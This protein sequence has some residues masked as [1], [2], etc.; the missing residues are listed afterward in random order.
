MRNMA[1]AMSISL[2]PV[3]LLLLLMFTS[4][5]RAEI[6][7]PAGDFEARYELSNG[8]GAEELAKNWRPAYTVTAEPD[9]SYFEMS[10]DQAGNA[11]G[12]V[13]Y[14]APFDLP[15][16][17]PVT[18]RFNFDMQSFDAQA[19]RAAGISVVILTEDG[20]NSLGETPDADVPNGVIKGGDRLFSQGVYPITADDLL[21]WTPAASTNLAR[22]IRTAPTRRVYIAIMVTTVH[23]GAEEWAKIRDFRIETSNEP[24]P[25]IVR[26][27]RWPLK[28]QRTL[29]T[30]EEITLARQNCDTFQSAADIRTNIINAAQRWMDLPDDEVRRRIP[31]ADV[32]RAANVNAEGCPIHG[33]EVYEKA[34]TYPWQ[35]DWDHPFTIKCPVG[36]EVY[37]ANDFYATYTDPEKS[38]G[39]ELKQDYADDGWGWVAPDGKRYWLVGY[40]CHWWWRNFVLPGVLNLSRAYVLTGDPAY[41]HKAAIML[42]RIAEEYPAMD[43]ESQSRYGS[44]TPGDYNG[45]ILNLIWETFTLTDLAEAYDNI[46]PAIDADSDLHTFLGKSG[47]QIRDNIETNLLQ[48]GIDCVFSQFI[49]GNF[50]MHQSALATASVVRQNCP[51][52]EHIQWLLYNTGAAAAHEGMQYALYN[53]VF[54]DG[55]P[56]ETS[57]GYCY[58]WV[59]KFALMAEV[60]RKT[61]ADFY[62]NPKFKTMFD[63]PYEMICCGTQTPAE[64]D[65]GSWKGGR[66]SAHPDAYLPALREYADPRYAAWLGG[67]D[68]G[69]DGGFRT[70][71][72]LFDPS[73]TQM[74]HDAVKDVDIPTPE[75]R[76]MPG[77]GLAILNNATN[78]LAAA[79]YYG[80]KG[81]HGHFDSL[82]L[83]LFDTKSPLLPDTGYPD[84]MNDYVPGIYSWSEQTIAH[85]TVTVDE[86]RQFGNARGRLM[87]FFNDGPLHLVTVDNPSV[88]QD[89]TSRYMR[90]LLLVETGENSGYLV[91][92]F[93]VDGGSQHN[94]SLHGA[95]GE[96]SIISGDFSAPRTEGTLAGPDV[97][98]GYFY[99]D[100]DLAKPG[101]SGGF[102][103]YKGSG[104][105]HLVNV[106]KQTDTGG[107]TV[108]WAP[109]Y[110]DTSRRVR[111]HLTDQ[112]DQKAI[113]A[114][115]QVSPVKNKELLKYVIGRREGTDLHSAYASVIEPFAT[116]ATPIVAS[117]TRLDTGDA[118]AVALQL[119][120]A[121]GL[122][123]VFHSPTSGA[124]FDLPGGVTFDGRFCFYHLA[125]DGTI[126]AARSVGGSLSVG[127]RTLTADATVSAEVIHFAPDAETITITGAQVADPASLAD[128]TVIIENELAAFP[129]LITTAEADGDDIILH[130]A[131]QE[132]R[133][134]LCKLVTANNQ[135]GA[136]TTDN[137]LPFYPIYNG[138]SLTSEDYSSFFHVTSAGSSGCTVDPA[139]LDIQAELTDADGDGITNFWFTAG[140]PGDMAR[141]DILSAA[142]N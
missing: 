7:A 120:R 31:G 61:D 130:V 133:S 40:A 76:L 71:A 28:T 12:V 80:Y 95:P 106:Q 125:Q 84:F 129:Y 56:H 23:A 51:V 60:M 87:E 3:T 39:D 102:S 94:Y 29:H 26:E 116:D 77:Y 81:G 110:P 22:I 19:D 99:D 43:Y 121:D 42:N 113:L 44:I 105:Q 137:I 62:A 69:D 8:I 64:G 30:D 97:P 20:W 79:M 10:G 58:L 108:E 16:H 96:F 101:Y 37:P 123:I 89:I 122:D 92:L 132:M 14:G 115:A 119:Q 114:D 38:F 75:T 25:P 15:D 34:G 88:Y 41:A 109:T 33:N 68:F 140:G 18:A 85:N 100:H 83:H 35:L 126:S 70:Y 90:T 9:G 82:N 36:G 78:S 45:K 117:V 107:V 131:G 86:R 93:R 66:L 50:G 52:D 48:E 112:P 104:F 21:E 135:T 91:D 5:A 4:C 111:L 1:S 59:D 65:S 73:P 46:Y 49:R 53:F 141:I 139:G 11:I 13:Y 47:E 32:P 24:L 138:A 74:V 103:R 118:D 134:G 2:I 72:G 136:I 63:A 98:L 67:D 124:S 128:R 57:P 142:T 6:L 55:M 17:A 54:R 127:G 27:R